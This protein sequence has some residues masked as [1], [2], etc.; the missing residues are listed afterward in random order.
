MARIIARAR[1]V[2]LVVLAIAVAVGFATWRANR[3]EAEGEAPRFTATEISDGV[4]FNE[5]PA[6]DR[7]LEL[8]RGPH[9]WP[10]TDELRAIQRDIN[11]AILA[12]PAWA[13]RFVVQM[14]SGD[15]LAVEEGFDGLAAIARRVL[16]ERYG[17]DAVDLAMVELDRK[18]VDE[19]LIRIAVLHNEFAFDNGH[20]VWYALDALVAAE[21]AAVAIA[22]LALV[23]VYFKV[24]K[25]GSEFDERIRLAHEILIAKIAGGLRVGF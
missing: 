12:D 13:D 9:P 24:L 4:L 11:N 1:P 21:V 6:A 25:P 16:D 23:G 10:W 17:P 8:N 2:L 19:K 22:V 14:Q 20:E 15:P 3:A 7:L 18:W 5:G